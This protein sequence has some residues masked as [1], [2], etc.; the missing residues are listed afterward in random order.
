[1]A[2]HAIA[3]AS[4]QLG[5]SP[6]DNGMIHEVVVV[7]GTGGTTGSYTTNFVKRP[8]RVAWPG[9]YTISGQVVTLN[10]AA[11]TGIAMATIIGYA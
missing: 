4:D 2:D 1:M 11:L 3:L 9:T 7:T 8:I 6:D 10:S 5:P